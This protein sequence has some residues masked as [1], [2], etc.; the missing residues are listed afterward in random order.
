MGNVCSSCED[1]KRRGAE[2][3]PPEELPD[4]VLDALKASPKADEKKEATKDGEKKVLN[5][6]WEIPEA[7][8]RLQGIVDAARS[9]CFAQGQ[10]PVAVEL[11]FTNGSYYQGQMVEKKKWGSGKYTSK[12]GRIY[13]GQWNNDRCNGKGHL[14]DLESFYYGFW[15]NGSK[16]GEGYEIWHA[17]GTQYIGQHSNSMKNGTG[18]YIWNDGTRYVGSFKN[19][20]IE[21]EGVFHDRDGVYKGAFVDSLQ[22]G[23]GTY[24]YTDGSVYTGQF[25]EGERHGQGK[26]AWEDGSS[27]EGQWADNAMHG[28]GVVV[29]KSGTQQKVVYEHGI[30][31]GGDKVEEK[32]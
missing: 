3:M 27:Y 16:E 17:D 14:K 5:H 19:D 6:V 25:Q 9:G 32:K 8:A 11:A 29:V 22:H 24:T 4:V 7:Q 1:G 2:D 30:Q 13:E 31:V 10:E 20:V 15:A 28:T 18:V 26:I 23:Y 21:G 12:E